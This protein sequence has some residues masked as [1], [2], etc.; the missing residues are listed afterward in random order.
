M[1]PAIKLRAVTKLYGDIAAVNNLNLEISEGEILGLIGPN[2]AG[3]TTTLKMIVGLLKPTSG[4]V[5]V[6]GQ[7]VSK[8]G[9]HVRKHIGYLPEED[10]LYENMTARQYLGFFSEIYGIS[11]TQA[12]DRIDSLLRSLKLNDENK[13]TGELSKGMKRKVAVART[14]LHDPPLLVLDEPNSG[15]DPLT[16]FF[17][18][19]YLKELSQNGKT[20]VLSAHNLFQIE[21]V[22]ERVAV[23]NNGELYICDTISSIRE[24]LGKREYEVIFS[25]DADLNYEMQGGNYIFRTADIKQITSLLERISE[26]NWILI[27]LSIQQPP[28]E[29]VYVRLMKDING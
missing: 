23:M 6:L 26:R 20:I 29:E 8:D 7:N 15:L 27:D 16:S 11:K 25:A 19:E 28:L 4:T 22:C 10:P 5:E 24:K 1:N 13:L 9:K 12:N 14:L 17:V 2:G 18:N 3:K 21:S